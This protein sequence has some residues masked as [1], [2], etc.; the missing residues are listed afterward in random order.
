MMPKPFT[1]AHFRAWAK[2]LILDNDQPWELERF[3]AD[4]LRDVFRGYLENLLVI[5]E[6]NAKTT[7]VAGLVLYH[8]LFRPRARVVVA[9]SS[10]EQAHWLFQ[11]AQGFVERSGLGPKEERVEHTRRKDA[12]DTFRCYE[13]IRTIRI[14]DSQIK[15]YASD[16]RT[17]D[18]PIFTLAVLK[19]LPRWRTFARAGS[20]VRP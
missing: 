10:K 13:G 17:A 8:A 19:V 2:G 16:D 5:P 7:L 6:G 4:W 3:Q 15:V 9:A 1:V 18:G 12:P 14:N 11:A 20:G